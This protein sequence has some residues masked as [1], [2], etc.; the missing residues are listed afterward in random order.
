[1]IDTYDH[2][3]NSGEKYFQGKYLRK[4]RSRKSNKKQFQLINRDV[5]VTPDEVFE[6]FI[7][8]D[9][10][11]AMDNTEYLLLIEQSRI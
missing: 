11:L 4:V 1:M 10:E 8:F 5:F 2:T 3:L 9:D 6:A 7:G